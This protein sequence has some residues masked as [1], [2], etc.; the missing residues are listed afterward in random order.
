MKQLLY[1]L[2]GITLFTSCSSDDDP[3]LPEPTQDYTSFTVAC[4]TDNFTVYNCI[5]GYKGSDDKWVRIAA[6]GDIKGK[7]ESKELK[8][9][10]SKVKEVY[11]FDDYYEN[12][13]Y[14]EADRITSSFK[15]T[16]NKKNQI[17]IPYERSIVKVNK[18]DPKQYPQE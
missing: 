14:K 18:D 12:G 2:L 4:E 9:D 5:I 11:I 7:T 3:V 13:V 1:I 16:E 17:I 6:L 10:F 8:V 15:I